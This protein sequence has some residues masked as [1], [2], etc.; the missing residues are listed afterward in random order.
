MTMDDCIRDCLAC[1]ARCTETANHS[2]EQGGYEAN[3]QH[4]RLLNDC[5]AI[6]RTSADFMLR[7]S[8]WHAR[9]CEVCAE[10]CESCAQDCERMVP[11]PIINACAEACRACAASCRE[12]VAEAAA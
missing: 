2:L 1:Y 10:I 9:T 8:L 6:C 11:D 12:M 5:A 7:R 4:V 3:A